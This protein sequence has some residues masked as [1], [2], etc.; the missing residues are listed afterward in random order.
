MEKVKLSIIVPVFNTEKYLSECLNSLINQTLKSIEIICVDDGSTDNSLSILEKFHSKDGR[1]KIIHQENF[2]VSV[3][4]NNGIAMAQGEYIGFVDSDDWVDADFFEK[5]YNA[6][7]KFGAE[8]VAGDF[9]WHKGNSQKPKMKYKEEKFYT[10]TAEKV[11]NALIPKLNYIW[12]KIYKRES[13]LKLNIPFEKDRYYEDMIWLV[14]V[15]YYMHGFVTVPNTFYHYRRHSESIVMQTSAKHL[16]DWAYAEKKMLDFM[17][18][19]NIPVLIP[20]K[21]AEK[22]KVALF[23]IDFLK[24]EYYLPNTTK[25]KLFGFLPILVVKKTF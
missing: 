15:I 2:G 12:N 14:Q 9:L 1:V 19:H 20:C 21:K 10:E 3:A 7:Q 25:Y 8:V 16:N 23:G 5:L 24:V 22:V 17:R 4:R 13:L 18:E 11:K 6:S